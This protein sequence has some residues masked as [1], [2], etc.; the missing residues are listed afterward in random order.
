MNPKNIFSKIKNHQHFDKILKWV[1][2]FSITGFVQIL[3]QV[4]GF[5]AGILIIRLLSVEEYALYTLANTMLG[6]MTVLAN[7]GLSTGVMALGGKNWDNREKLSKIISTGMILRKKFGILSLLISLPILIYLL[8]EHQVSWFISLLISA[9]IIPA[10]YAS[11]SDSLLETI[12]KLKQDIIPLQK[13]QLQVAIFRA[14]LNAILLFIFPITSIALIANGLP[15]IY[16]N[17]KLKKLISKHVDIIKKISPEVEKELTIIVKRVIPGA[18]YFAFSSQITVWIISLYGK[19]SSIA[20]IGALSRFGMLFTFITSLT[21]LLII[22]R[23]ARLNNNKQILLK[24]TIQVL[25]LYLILGLFII[26][27]TIIF[28]DQLL[29]ILGNNYKNLNN[30]L[31]LSII[32]SIINLFIGLFA[33]FTYSKGWIVNP[34]LEISISI[35]SIFLGIFLFEINTLKGVLLFTIFI[36]IIKA[37]LFFNYLLIKIFQIKN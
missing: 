1:K 29:W 11:L 32:A 28:S 36:N 17:I 25:F 22:P 31:L 20:E 21:S 18:F 3:I 23:F 5:I 35:L 13:N 6:T 2:L 15:R 14:F 19:T 24:K 7:G 16:G 9:S 37:I 4:I 33:S 12:P 8:R 34:I 30:E 10:F 26:F 27:L